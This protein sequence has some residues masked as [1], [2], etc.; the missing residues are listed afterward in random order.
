M[1]IILNADETILKLLKKF[2][3]TDNCTRMIKYCMEKRIEDGMLLFN[4]L[5]REMVLLTDEEYSH[6]T[7]LEYLKEHW[8]VVPDD[9]KEKEYAG[10]V[11]W[12]FSMQ[13][14][15]LN[16]I[17]GYTIF[18]TTDCN[19]R[20][21]YCFEHKF[22]RITMTRETALK[23]VEYIKEHSCG[24]PVWLYWFG[25]E[26]LYN[27]EAI[28]IICTGLREEGIKYSSSMTTNGYLFDDEVVKKAVELWN[29]KWAQ[30]TL[31][32]T[33]EIYNRIKAYIYKDGNPY[34]IVLKNIKRLSD[35]GIKINIRLN[36]DLDNVDNLLE[37]AEELKQHFSAKD[38][39][40]VY[41]YH[42]FKND[43]SM[44]ELH[45]DDEWRLRDEAMQRIEE[46]LMEGDL[47]LTPRISNK[48][49]TNHCMADKGDSVSIFPDGNVGLCDQYEEPEYI[50][51]I[52]NDGFD[53]AMAES[54]RE[55]M[56]EIPECENC[57]LYPDC[58]KI[59]R[60]RISNVCFSC[61][62]RMR[63][64]N[65]ERAMV[66]EYER[67]LTNALPEDDDTEISEH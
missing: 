33:E 36:M 20:C 25:G 5:T 13:R 6:F 47:L 8:F 14:K 35:A 15:N 28:D 34:Q 48:L 41:I 45:S 7:D 57:L 65:T 67:W 29:L 18:P 22:S 42:L 3:K 44:A 21:F 26:P 16:P 51:N 4:V 58:I 56:P 60:C 27:R 49:K 39:V 40:K 52:D 53:L 30:I 10:F 32:G 12:F 37:L 50:G 23:V 9:A 1:K 63:L 46:K 62:R 61:Y 55:T 17:T 66:S 2:H 24:N 31:D 38:K 19:A 64:S 54:W 59:K 43:E 11:K